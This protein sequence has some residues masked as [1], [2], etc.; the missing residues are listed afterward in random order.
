MPHGLT[1]DWN[2]D[3]YGEKQSTNHPSCSMVIVSYW[4]RHWYPQ[5]WPG[6]N[7][8]SSHHVDLWQANWRW[9]RFFLLWCSTANSHS[10]KWSTFITHPVSRH[11]TVLILTMSLQNQIKIMSYCIGNAVIMVKAVYYDCYTTLTVVVS[12][13]KVF[14]NLMR[15]SLGYTAH[16]SQA[17][18]ICMTRSLNPSAFSRLSRLM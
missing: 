1:R 15:K 18:N 3:L 17:R 12:P 13:R 8:K 6:F 4:S 9:G 14:C 11:Y 2:W 16:S 7:P 10:T 5:W